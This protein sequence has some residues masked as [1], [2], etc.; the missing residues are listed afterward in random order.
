MKNKTAVKWLSEQLKPSIALQT[1]YIDE[2]IEYAKQLEKDQMLSFANYVLDNT[3]CSFTGLPNV[4]KSL[5][6][7]YNDFYET[8]QQ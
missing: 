6:D 7:L 4:S 3:E 8:Q 1:K 5:I 2:F